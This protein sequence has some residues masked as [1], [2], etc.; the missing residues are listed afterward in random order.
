MAGP[1]DGRGERRLELRRRRSRVPWVFSVY[2]APGPHPGGSRPACLEG[3]Y[4]CRRMNAGTSS[5]DGSPVSPSASASGAGS[6]GDPFTTA[7]A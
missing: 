3:V 2:H 5:A 4:P 6:A 7:R 1:D